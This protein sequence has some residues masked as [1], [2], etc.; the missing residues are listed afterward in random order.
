MRVLSRALSPLS[1]VLGAA[2]AAG[3]LAGPSWSAAPDPGLRSDDGPAVVDLG[4]DRVR[5]LPAGGDR[6]VLQP[7]RRPD[8]STPPLTVTSDGSATTVEVADDADADPVVVAGSRTP[9]TTRAAEDP[10][11]ADDPVELRF[12]A[13]GRDGRPSYAHINIFDVETGA[14]SMYRRLPGDPDAPCTSSSAACVLVPPGT[15]SLMALVATMPADKPSTPREFTIQNLSL[16]GDPEVEVTRDRTV[17]FDA[18]RARRIEVRTPGHDTRVNNDGALELGYTRT[19]ENGKS[20]HV[21]QNPGSPLDQAFYLE[22]TKQVRHGELETS[23]RLRLEAPSIRLE[24]P[25]VRELHPYYYDKDW[26]SDR[27]T[28]FPMYDGRDRLRVVDAGHAS[29]DDLRGLDLRGALAL[30]ERSDEVPVPEQANNAAAKGAALVVIYN[31][32]PGDNGDPGTPGVLLDVPTLRLSRAEG[33]ALLGLR[34]QD[35]VTVTGRPATPYVYDLMLKEHGRVRQQPTYTARRGPHG[36]LAEQVH[37]FYGQPERE[38]T[39]AEAAYPWWPGETSALSTTFPVRGGPQVRH[40]YRFADP[41]IRWS[42]SSDLPEPRY[43]NRFPREPVQN[44]LFDDAGPRTLTAGERTPYAFG[45]APLTGS[46]NPRVPLERSGDRMRLYL[47]PFVDG[48]GHGSKAQTDES[49][50]SVH[51]VVTADGE[52]LADTT[53]RPEGVV[54]LPGGDARIGIDLTVDNP[55]SWASLSTHTESH[56]TFPSV[57]VPEGEVARQPALVADYDVDVDLDNRSRS[58]WFG[59]TL[60]HHDGS[61]APIR[62]TVEVSYDDG[63][64]WHPATVRGDRVQL[65]KGHGYVSLRVHAADDA[66]ST[67]EQTVV[68]AW[69]VR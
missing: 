69:L 45:A 30:V 66:G 37:T 50:M 53:G 65:P 27:S 3:A 4:D 25:R 10:G 47:A 11:T 48:D 43:G 35:R 54:V 56:W 21:W 9:F 15:Y 64:T 63:A 8:G 24:A 42:F 55:Q 17:T 18:R 67:L 39:F 26:F 61:R 60:S 29:P 16:V 51:T 12:E 49:G 33:L 32:S 40:E 68:R 14:F 57:A 28:R 7:E 2:L 38:D 34:R 31:D 46:I 59:L 20:M 41:D 62:T 5:L 1:L 6:Q 58:R 13:L 19:A 22:P 52:V 23:A 44:L 36:N